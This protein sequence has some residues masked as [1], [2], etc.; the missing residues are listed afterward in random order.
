M[1]EIRALRAGYGAI[2]ILN[3]VELSVAQGEVVGILGH[4]GM[5]KTTLLRSLIGELPASAGEIRFDGAE[6]AGWQSHRRSLAG[7]G[8]VPQGRAIFPDLTVLENLRM[9]E[10]MRPGPSAIPEILGHFPAL[11]DLL[12]RPGSGLSGGQQQI[13]ALAR[14]LVGRPKLVMLD[15]PTEGIQPSIVE[16]IAA[17]LARLRR[18]LGLTI[19]LVEQDLRFIE[20]LADRVLIIQKGRISAEIAPSELRRPDILEAHLGL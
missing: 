16:E 12:N 14:C 8:Y 3:G 10:A 9:G 18:E 19:L 6:I 13:L 7:L 17:T 20:A 11:G 5:G 2:N 1:L 4:N 15:E